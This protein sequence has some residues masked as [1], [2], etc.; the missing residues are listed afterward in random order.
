[1]GKNEK[2]GKFAWNKKKGIQSIEN[3]RLTFNNTTK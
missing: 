2:F 1:M 3:F